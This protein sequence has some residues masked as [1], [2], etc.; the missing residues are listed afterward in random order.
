M[1]KI[2]YSRTML[3]FESLLIPFFFLAV[4]I[5]RYKLDQ[6]DA[7]LLHMFCLLNNCE[8]LH[9]RL[10]KRCGWWCKLYYTSC[11]L[12]RLSVFFISWISRKRLLFCKSVI[13]QDKMCILLFHIPVY[14]V[15]NVFFL[16]KRATVRIKLEKKSMKKTP[17]D[18][19]N[20]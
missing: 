4:C 6:V 10:S 14:Y 1:Q 16:I 9:V 17:T 20:L 15:Q 12:S 18:E 11:N 5:V 13:I 2:V 19:V 8:S 7:I 3:V